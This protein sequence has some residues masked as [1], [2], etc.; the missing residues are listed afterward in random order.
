M[1]KYDDRIFQASADSRLSVFTIVYPVSHGLGVLGIRKVS[2]A[3][4][5]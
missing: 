4:P 2:R 1:C 5:C 3:E